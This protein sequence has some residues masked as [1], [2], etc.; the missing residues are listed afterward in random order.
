MLIFLCEIPLYKCL[1]CWEINK[2]CLNQTKSKCKEQTSSKVNL[3]TVY[4]DQE[5]HVNTSN[6]TAVKRAFNY[7][8]INKH[9]VE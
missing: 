9:F 5:P 8:R 2:I 6:K 4:I 3:A 7:R 1:T